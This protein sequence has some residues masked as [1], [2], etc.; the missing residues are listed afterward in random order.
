M[1][2]TAS[3]SAT[4]LAPTFMPPADYSL[5]PLLTTTPIPPSSGSTLGLRVTIIAY[6]YILP[7]ICVLG[8]IGNLMNV[9][10]LASNRLRA[11]S[12]LYLRALAVAD[13]LCM[14]FVLLFV[15]GE[16]LNQVGIAL[17][18]NYWYGFYQAHLMLS[19]INWALST[20]VCVVLALSLERYVSVVFPMHFR[21]WNSPQRA[22]KAIFISYIVPF[23]FYFPYGI[24]RYSVGDKTT[25]DNVT[26]IF[27]A[28]DSETSKT[29][30]WKVMLIDQN[31]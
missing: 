17:N 7:V 27:M 19:L 11:V 30:A 21:A 5:V 20:G 15:S 31:C 26:T 18:R 25:S 14:I 8:I 6:C 24:A 12:Y 2:D 16:I 29:F 10:T 3:I 23:I 1:N 22:K 4:I 9:V 13:L 28:I